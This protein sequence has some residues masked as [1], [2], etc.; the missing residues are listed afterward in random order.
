MNSNINQ[1]LLSVCLIVRNEEKLLPSCL[2]S[3]RSVADEI[4]V[5]NT[6]S[7]DKTIEIARNFGAIILEFPWKN[8]FSTA[9][10]FGLSSAKGAWILQ[11]DADEQLANPEFSREILLNSSPSIG[12]YLISVESSVARGNE[13]LD[14]FRTSICRIFRNNQQIRFQ[15]IIHEQIIDSIISAGFS[16]AKSPLKII[17]HGYNLASGELHRKRIRNAELLNSALEKNPNDGY[18]LLQRGKTYISLNQ[19]DNALQDLERAISLADTP[20]TS[21]IQALNY[22]ALIY[23]QRQNYSIA[24]AKAQESLSIEPKQNFAEYIL[25]EVYSAL[26]QFD[27]ALESY[28]KMRLVQSS[29]NI[30]SQISGDYILPDEQLCFRI[31]RSLVALR[32]WGQADEEFRNGLLANPRDVG[33]LVGLADLA[34][35]SNNPE[36][37]ISLLNDAI[38][39]DPN[40]A[41]LHG[42]LAVANSIKEQSVSKFQKQKNGSLQFESNKLP[43]ISGAVIVGDNVDGFERAISSLKQFCDEIVV[44]NNG[45][46]D[47]ADVLSQKFGVK[48]FRI[49]WQNDFSAARN[50]A[51]ERCSGDWIV[52]LDSD[53]AISSETAK[54]I[55]S[56]VNSAPENVGGI[57][58]SISHITDKIASQTEI[59]RIFRNQPAIRYEGFIHEQATSGIVRAGMTIAQSLDIAFEH[60]SKPIDDT[61]QLR[62]RKLLL[63]EIERQGKNSESALFQYDLLLFNFGTEDD[64]LE[65]LEI[66]DKYFQHPLARRENSAVLLNSFARLLHQKDNHKQLFV[67]AKDSVQRFPEQLEGWW[68]LCIAAVQLEEFGEAAH[69]FEMIFSLVKSYKSSLAFEKLPKIEE[70]IA[71]ALEFS[72]LWWVRVGLSDKI[73]D[74]NESQNFQLFCELTARFSRQNQ[75]ETRLA[76]AASECVELN[77][78]LPSAIFYRE[79]FDLVQK[80]ASSSPEFFDLVRKVA[81]NSGYQPLLMILGMNHAVLLTPFLENVGLKPEKPFITLSMIVKNE[82]KFLPDCL[83]SVRGIVDEIVIADTGSTDKTLEIARSFGAKIVNFPWQNDFS[84]ARNASLQNCTGEWILYLDADERIDPKQAE[85]IRSTLQVAPENV[86]ALLCTIFS[87]HRFDN[88]KAEM[89]SGGYPRIFRNYGYP[90]INFI[91]RVHEQITPSILELGKGI[92]DSDIVIH[93]LGY[94]QSREVMESKIKRN[95]SLLLDHIKEEPENAYAWFQLAQTLSMMKLNIQAEEAFRLALRIGKLQPHL[96][97]SAGAA[98]AQISGNSQNFREALK[99]ANF[100]LEKAPEQVYALHLKAYSLLYLKRFEEAEQAFLEVLRRIDSK[101]STPKTGFD[102]DVSKET[103]LDGLRKAHAKIG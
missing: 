30:I 39:I 9:R 64:Y 87:P 81:E 70:I 25:G 102:I 59:L 54:K 72:K 63:K 24:I 76:K 79:I 22:A 78:W 48:I 26:G 52:M 17:H 21:R 69:A 80:S 6:G 11:I 50:S 97:A 100:S 93:H 19:P 95:Y 66:L 45:S 75:G 32:Q 94:D 12:G 86:G 89:H 74:K 61:K 55:R 71:L 15:G 16:I 46:T 34:L 62:Y 14:I 49:T 91:G 28:S 18:L 36:K 29:D 101:R 96:E 4:I 68:N 5:V 23:F 51:L 56:A 73:S 13:E 38:K 3:I 43:T 57:I 7:T 85:Y 44:V 8:D 82:E 41:D 84:A 103:I 98:L 40:R 37:A 92:A 2:A 83:E 65:C 60:Y 20:T 33:C 88:D 42:F 77:L 90:Q 1:P 53:E 58:T 99:W 35:K 47:A 10:N 27:S 31:G 67:V